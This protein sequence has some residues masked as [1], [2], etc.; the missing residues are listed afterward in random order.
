MAKRVRVSGLPPIEPAK[1]VSTGRGPRGRQGPPGQYIPP[2]NTITVAESG[3]DYTNIQQA[4]DRCAA[5]GG[6]AVSIYPGTYAENI[7][8][9]DGVTVVGHGMP[10]LDGNLTIETGGWVR[11]LKV[12][13]ETTGIC[14]REYITL[15]NAGDT[16][17]QFTAG[18]PAMMY[19][20]VM[21]DGRRYP[22]LARA[23]LE[24]LA[25]L[26]GSP[27]DNS[28]LFRLYI[29]GI[30]TIVDADV[31]VMTADISPDS[32]RRSADIRHI[33]WPLNNDAIV[34]LARHVT[35]G[36]VRLYDARLVLDLLE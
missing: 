32:L 30:G 14:T 19:C 11:F 12:L 28:G 7:T 5:E 33:L 4:I 24:I 21:W 29:V 1:I 22:F 10:V 36:S 26:G 8:V 3:G 2:A 27:L 31:A 25:T 6:G 16:G 20:G 17:T 13:G 23:Y 15:F 18:L 35:S 34:L 9:P